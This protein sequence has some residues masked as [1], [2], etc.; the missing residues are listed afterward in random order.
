MGM[1]AKKWQ[2]LTGML[3]LA[4]GPL[5]SSE[6]RAQAGEYFLAP[7][8][9]LAE[10]FDDNV[11]HTSSRREHDFITRASPIVAGGYRSAPLTLIGYYTFDADYYSRHS[12]FTEFNARE[13]AGLDFRYLPD[14]R[15]TLSLGARYTETEISSDLNFET[16]L[17]AGRLN[18][19][20]F[21]IT[22]GAVYR[23]DAR[24]AGNVSY[25]FTDDKIQGEGGG[26]GIDTET[27]SATVGLDYRVTRRDTASLAY[28][29]RRFNFEGESEDAHVPTVGW[30]HQLTRLTS[31][32]LA[33][34][35]RF[36]DGDVDPEVFALIRHR[37]DRGELTFG[38]AHSQSTVLGQI[39][40]VET[41][42]F[43]ATAF[44][45]PDRYWQ[46][47]AVP[48]YVI[49][50]RRSFEAKVFRASFEVSYQLTSY[51]ALIGA[52][53]FTNQ[54]GRLDRP[55]G[56]DITRNVIM[57]GIVL[58]APSWPRYD[59]RPGRSI[60]PNRRLGPDGGFTPYSGEER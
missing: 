51:M 14:P 19:E 12:E 46:F 31:L 38:Y 30:T 33:A 11:F 22:P 35:P 34:G 59:V 53:E 50:E 26:P 18:A 57:V 39:G 48:S 58:T 10:V 17:A 56:A 27:H 45:A 15:L 6:A 37:L 2:C 25:T 28:T 52:Y 7:S 54:D 29:Y 5:F 23:F 8:I 13:E 4:V 3:L 60:L 40:A 9:T 55:G 36:S 41:D 21:S 1:N 24:T 42:S 44:Y 47:R 43:E 49:S 32:T 16:G 20:R